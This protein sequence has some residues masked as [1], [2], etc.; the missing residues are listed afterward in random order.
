VRPLKIEKKLE[1]STFRT[2][3][4]FQNSKSGKCDFFLDW[5]QKRWISE[6]YVAETKNSINCESLSGNQP[7]QS[8]AS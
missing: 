4:E 5:K 3:S 8:L 2:K 1:K 6:F 7:K